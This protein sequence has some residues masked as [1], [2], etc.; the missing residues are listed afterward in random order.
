MP[1]R[2][3]F[4]LSGSQLTQLVEDHYNDLKILKQILE[5]LQHRSK[6]KMNKLQKDVEARIKT[7]SNGKARKNTDNLNR[8]QPG[9]F[10]EEKKRNDKSKKADEPKPEKKKE[11]KHKAN[12]EPKRSP[13]L[14]KMRKPGKIDGL[15]TKT[16]IILKDEIKLNIKQGTPL[17]E[18]YEAGVKAL[19][20]KK[21]SLQTSHP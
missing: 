13:K 16:P 5:E 6:P 3:Y 10:D 21:Y 2:H 11:A 8:V 14:G 9:L 18:R 7:F 20:K 15:P 4:N 17:V 1:N 19:V 12:S